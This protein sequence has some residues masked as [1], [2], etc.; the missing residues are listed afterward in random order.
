MR[1]NRN[2]KQL[3]QVIVFAMKN[4]MMNA[5]E[6][7]EYFG[8]HRQTL[9]M[10]VTQAR[11]GVKDFPLPVLPKGARLVWRRADI[12]EYQSSIGNDRASAKSKSPAKSKARYEWAMRKLEAMSK[13]K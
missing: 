12:L 13:K 8:I 2:A 9:K 4:E 1:H 6:V 10:W 5:A 11:A 7:S 3:L